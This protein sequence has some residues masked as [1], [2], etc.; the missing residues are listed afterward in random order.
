M[1]HTGLDVVGDVPWGTHFCQFYQ[2]R[3]D[4]VDVLVP[5][6]RQGL[7]NNEFCMWVTSRPLGIDQAK[8]ALRR[9]V[10]D[11]DDRI[12]RGQI[13]ILSYDQWYRLDGRFDAQ[14]VLQGWVQKE[15]AAREHGF[16][17]LRLTGNT[18]WLEQSDWKSFA[19]YEE[20]VNR[21]I[22]KHRML[23]LCTYRL[24]R[25]SASEIIDVVKTHQFAMIKR[26]G[27]W[28][29]IE[30]EHHKGIEAARRE[31]E[32]SAYNRRLIEASLDPL[33]T[34][35]ADGKVTDVNAA[36]EKVTGRSR[37][38]L[39]GTDFSDYFT[40]PD[41]ARAGYQQV[42]REGSVQDY[43]LEIRHREGRLTP[44]LYNASVYRDSDGKVIGVFAAARDVTERRQM[45]A[46]LRARSL[47]ARSLIEASLDPLVTI[48]PEGKITDVNKA[49]EE[50]TGLPREKLIGT[51]FSEYFTQRDKAEAGY[52]SVL[53]DG[54]VRDYPLTLLHASGNTMDVLYNATVYRN[55]A[56]RV[57]GVFAAA[58]DITE[59]K[60]AEEARAQ[61]A[62]IV[63]SSDDAI[64]AKDLD[65]TILSWN[66]GA[67]RIYG[68]TAAEMI[69]R[70]ITALCPADHPSEIPQML[71]RIRRGEYVQH[72][73]T[74]R[75][76]KD[77][78]LIN[79]SLTMSPIRD[80]S[81][82]IIG[83][84]TIA[85]DI[86][87]HKRAEEAL[88]L[89]GAYNR[90]LIEAS[91]DPLVTID[92]N[93]RIMDVNAATEKVTGR[94]RQELIG[95]DFS[96]YFTEPEKAR[97]GY[98]QVFRE[99]SVQD[100]PLEIRHVD[101]HHTPVLYNASVYRDERGKIIG[102]FAAARDITRIRQA[103]LALRLAS[104]Y[105]RSLIEA[106]LDPLVTVDD[107]GKIMDVNAA[108]EKV[109]G[110]S[111]LELIGTDVSG[112]FTE[113][114]R[115]RAGYQ[116]VFREGS[117]QDYALEIRHR[118]GHHTPVVYNASVYR[119]EGGKVIGLF[120]A[121]RDV[122]RIRQAE[123]ALRIASTYN[124]SLIE[125]S[126]D[127]LVTIDDQGKI[128]DVNAATEKVTGRSRSELIGTDFT[129]YFTEPQRARAGYQQ[130]FREGSVQDYALEIRHRDGHHTPVL[131][132]ASV[133]R[134][135][136]GKVIGVFAAAR[137][138]TE[139]RRVEEE[140]R[141]LN[142]E[143]EQRVVART[144][145]LAA[146]NKELEAFAYSVSHDLRAPL[147]GIDGFAQALLEDYSEKLD[148]EG[149]GHLQRVRAASQRMGQL[150][151]GIL[152]LSRTT[153]SE[154]RRAAVNLSSLAQSIAG[155][156]QKT[157]PN[158]VANFVIAPGLLVNADA[159][160]LRILLEN[161]LGNAWKFTSKHPIARI[162][163]GVMQQDGENVYLVRD[164]GAGFDMAHAANLFGAFRRLHAL[165][166]FEGTGIGLA[167]VQRIVHRHGGR[168]WA[169]G[170]VEKGATFY[171]TMPA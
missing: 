12:R 117:V 85:R 66:Q 14:R 132:N 90:S 23:A 3:Q 109:T 151:D 163:V 93:G 80:G 63:E 60:R 88:R 148:P 50:A 146:S 82:K 162:E 74:V 73:E 152:S 65:G 57:Q 38:E 53:A 155:D 1:R 92:A 84:S 87:E 140:L 16:D 171:F 133:Y 72:Y 161:L 5:Y 121:A 96:D 37:T 76:T 75:Q 130:V 102:I 91:L 128:T 10:P 29:I 138:I 108:M 39:I 160:L 145:E 41:K 144:A 124:R 168:V 147:R 44:V 45:E 17:G 158:R 36:T 15:Q 25:C 81:G 169:E 51:N 34:I 24:D 141:R 125:A 99:G 119:D 52:R 106:S 94:T 55:E 107:Q 46:E 64:K 170:Q 95:A 43:A 79:V 83:A 127:P 134:D 13:E 103:E 56:G 21:A 31:T 116:K 35:D 112:Y 165:T 11:L 118:D 61:L 97:A 164:D 115:A 77:G 150:I 157:E 7:E 149:K 154:M 120:A 104:A 142:D 135:A 33:I 26:M 153:R 58:R 67:T 4:L 143:L 131:Y 54:L 113:P 20:A 49:T 30:N 19:D 137:D 89:A 100:Y 48:S 9:A 8:R 139:R 62:A 101:G 105:N 136:A 68:Y 22:G 167:T 18:C 123:E 126:L 156:L 28:E 159:G 86:S 69:G 42:F 47:Y 2:T 110:H 59:R 32:T 70:S 27:K 71:D 122:T 166:E 111:R 40:Q 129:D 6:F 114:E 98:Q 78:R